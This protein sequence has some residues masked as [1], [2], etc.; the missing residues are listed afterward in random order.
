VWVC[1]QYMYPVMF[2]QTWLRQQTLGED[3][4]AKRKLAL[5]RAKQSGNITALE[6]Y[7]KNAVESYLAKKSGD[8]LMARGEE[9]CWVRAM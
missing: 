6:L 9:C 3:F 8:F 4:W 5:D 1:A 2:L 7:N